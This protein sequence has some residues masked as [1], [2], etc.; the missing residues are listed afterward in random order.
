MTPMNRFMPFVLTIVLAVLLQAGFI[1]LDCKHS[2]YQV[3]AK[4][5]QA[6]FRLDPAMAD[7]LCATAK[8][9]QPSAMVADYIFRTREETS[10]RGFDLGMAKS[11]LY[12]VKTHTVQTSDTDA[13]VHFT[14]LRRTAINPVFPVI[15][16][17]FDLGKEYKVD[18]TIQMIK[19]NGKWKV[20]CPVFDLAGT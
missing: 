18:E 9:S 13:Q 16:K 5:A 17:L 3:A 6:Y 11:V 8:P 19:E 1:A 20:C 12:H 10:K 7:Q 15:A 2:P 4:F 14:A